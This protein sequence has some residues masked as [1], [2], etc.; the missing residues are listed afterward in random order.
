[1][2]KLALRVAVPVLAAAAKLTVADPLPLFA[3]ETVSH[4]ALLLTVQVQPA[5]VVRLTL[6]LPPLAA[7]LALLELKV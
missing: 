3:D 2:A 4:V 1:M 5:P 7:K 6:P